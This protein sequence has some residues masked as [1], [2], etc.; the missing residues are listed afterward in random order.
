MVRKIIVRKGDITKMHTDVIVNAANPTLLGGGGVDDAIHAA[1]G[2]ELL[3]ECSQIGGIAVGEAVMTNGYNLIA[4][5]IIHT[6]GPDCR[7]CCIEDREL[8]LESAWRNSLALAESHGVGSI[9][10]PSISTGIYAYPLDQAAYIAIRTISKFLKT[11][12]IFLNE[13][14][15]VCFDDETFSKYRHEV[16]SFFCFDTDIESTFYKDFLSIS[17]VSENTESGSLNSEQSKHDFLNFMRTKS[18]N[19]CRNLLMALDYFPNLQSEK[20][21]QILQRVKELNQKYGCYNIV[22]QNFLEFAYDVYGEEKIDEF[23]ED[24]DVKEK[25]HDFFAN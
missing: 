8:L 7:Y 2:P 15:I 19:D 21:L 1:A 20:L 13:V 22:Y 5:K 6:V 14:H 23:L 25:I 12:S 9:A 4:K 24:D 16:Q 17:F 10:F 3:K 18:V 11:E